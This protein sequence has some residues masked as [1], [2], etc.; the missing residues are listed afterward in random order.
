[1]SQI[2]FLNINVDHLRIHISQS[3]FPKK[4]IK[5]CERFALK[6]HGCNGR[7]DVKAGFEIARNDTS[8]GA[9]R[10]EVC[11]S[12]VRHEI[13]SEAQFRCM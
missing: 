10:A 11:A 8:V 3:T 5:H 4:D 1:M 13:I 9:S 6:R 12:H 7:L 2:T